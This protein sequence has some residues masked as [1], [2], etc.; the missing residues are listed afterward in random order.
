MSGPDHAAETDRSIELIRQDQEARQEEEKPGK[1]SA[2]TMLVEI[3]LERYR[4]GV[5]E[6]AETF[7]VPKKGPL[8]VQLL[9]GG[10]TSLRG[11]LSRA[12][13]RMTGRAV[14]QQAL[15]DALTTLDGFAQEQAPE[16]LWQRVAQQDGALW[17]DLGDQTGR[18]V[19]V[20]PDGWTVVDRP[21]VLF[22]RTT[23]TGILPVPVPD[24]GSEMEELWS[25]VPVAKEDQ[26]LVLAE[27]VHRMWPDQPHV[28]TGLFGEQGSGKSTA[29]RVL[30]GLT[31]PSPVP[32]RKA[33]RDPETWVTA[34]AGSWVVALDNLSTLP[35][36]LQDS[37]CRAS[38]GD[39]DVRRKLYTDGEY[40]TFAFRRCVLVTG[41]DLGALNGDFTDRLLS[42][43]LDPISEGDRVDE[44]DLWPQW[45][46]AH[47]RLLGAVLSLTSQVMAAMGTVRLARRPRMADFARRLCAVDQILGTDGM[48]RYMGAQAR[49]A[50]DSLTGDP[51][52][53]RV[54]EEL[55]DTFTGT[56]GELLRKVTP[57]DDRRLP[58]GWPGTARAVTQRLH[59]QA[60]V[61]RKAGWHVTDDGGRNEQHATRWTITPPDVQEEGAK[62]SSSSSS[63]RGGPAVDEETSHAS[64]DSYLPLTPCCETGG[65]ITGRCQLCSKSPTFWRN[66]EGTS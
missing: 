43:T 52:I 49:M 45:E 54:R 22:R 8:V 39:G 25:L 55:V 51:F 17:L 38:T 41:I 48:T 61:M 66:E 1:K 65:P 14:G 50:S 15:S 57:N 2:A 35:D 64:H 24:A 53:A 29:A 32:L 19:R 4:L 33:P 11:E 27:L 21:P 59:K 31:D 13:F 20:T 34:A 42:I 12:F 10:K 30:T 46:G 63:P 23:L 36:W 37:I 6:A 7:A 44:E 40:A 26:P 62:A 9:R 28:V 18:A 58:K 47:P 3:A 56:A 16:R 5:S 60:P